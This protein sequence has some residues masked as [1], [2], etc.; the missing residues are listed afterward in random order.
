[1]SSIQDKWGSQSSLASN[2]SAVNVPVKATTSFKMPAPQILS[3]YSPAFKRKS[4]S[5][6]NTGNSISPLN[7]NITNNSNQKVNQVINSNSGLISD[8]PK[9]LESICSPTRSDYSFEYLSSTGSPENL[10]SRPRIGQ[11]KTRADYDD[12]D[13]DSAVSSSQSSIS[14][15]F[16]PPMS[17]VP[18]DRST[19]SSDRS[20]ISSEMN[21]QRRT[22]I[23]ES[24]IKNN[25]SIITEGNSFSSR[26]TII[27]DRTYLTSNS[28]R[29]SIGSPNPRPPTE[30][31]KNSQIPQRQVLKRTNSSDTNCSSSS[32]LTSG[33]QVQILTS[34]LIR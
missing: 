19:M 6:Y 34:L 22:L 1:M 18:S 13:N 16:S 9:S 33:S 5:V 15:G 32:T 4:L 20:Y 12:S 21:Y 24:P 27:T 26:P 31:S 7:Y 29:S 23:L 10:R 8:A 14:R 30:N 3:K 28:E 2:T 17:P 25:E 11:K